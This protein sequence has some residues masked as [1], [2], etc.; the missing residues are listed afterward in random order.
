[1]GQ[2]GTHMKKYEEFHA[3]L[4]VSLATVVNHFN[5]SGKELKKVAKDVLRITGETPGIEVAMIE[6][7][8]EE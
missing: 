8:E 1:V 7:P 2:L 5:N 6:R 3:K 4:G